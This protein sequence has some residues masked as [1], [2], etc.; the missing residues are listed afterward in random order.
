MHC[1]PFYTWA[2]S[3]VARQC[4]QAYR[5]RAVPLEEIKYASSAE[6]VGKFRLW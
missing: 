3:A 4:N 2:G 1:S 5:R 6:F